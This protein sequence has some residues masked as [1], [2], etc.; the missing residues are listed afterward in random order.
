MKKLLIVTMLSTLALSAQA[1]WYVQGDLGAS[2]IDITDL[3]SSDSPSFTQRIS[4][5]YAFDKNFRLAVDYTN[6][7]KVTANYDD[8][9]DVSLKV[10]SLGFTGFYDFDLADFKPYVGVRVSTNKADVTAN[11]RL[12][13]Y[14]VEVFATETRTGIGALAGVQYKLTDNVALNT[15]IEYSYLASNVSDVGVKAGLRFSF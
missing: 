4:V 7:G 13:S 6:Y 3:N 12:S 15:N 1:Q 5:G 11:V 8:I 9:A 10:K 14:G 2:K